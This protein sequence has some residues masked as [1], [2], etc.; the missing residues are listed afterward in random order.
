VF[1]LLGPAIAALVVFAFTFHWNSFLCPL[2][3]LQSSE[4]QTGVLALNRLVSYT[5]AITF[6][7]VVL[8]AAVISVLPTVLLFVVLRRYF[9]AGIAHTGSKG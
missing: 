1:P 9:I 2:T 4:Q 3:V 5:S 6:Q 7:N 8:A